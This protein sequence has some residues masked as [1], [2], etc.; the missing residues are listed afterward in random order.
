[1][2]GTYCTNQ[3]L[4]TYQKLLQPPYANQPRAFTHPQHHHPSTT[5]H[6]FPNCLP[7]SSEL[8]GAVPGAVPGSPA[9]PHPNTRLIA[10][11]DLLN[12]STFHQAAVTAGQPSPSITST[13]RP[14][15]LGTSSLLEPSR[16]HLVTSQ[17]PP[18][19][20]PP[21]CNAP[22]P[23]HSLLLARSAEICPS[24]Q[25]SAHERLP[26]IRLL[27]VPHRCAL[28]HYLPTLST[29]ARR[30]ASSLGTGWLP[31]CCLLFPLAR[32]LGSSSS[33]A[34]FLFRQHHFASSSRPQLPFAMPSSQTTFATTH[35]SCSKPS[36][37][38][39]PRLPARPHPILLRLANRYSCHETNPLFIVARPCA[40]L[41][42]PENECCR[43][44]KQRATVRREPPERRI[45]R[46]ATLPIINLLTTAFL[47]SLRAYILSTYIGRCT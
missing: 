37:T 28:A 8:P 18:T 29:H 30:L 20:Q 35:A 12:V 23:G 25:V 36:P 17:N 31:L 19:A 33:S 45:H 24:S 34:H 27:H 44:A 10:L 43:P 47:V 22:L 5:T 40:S 26:Q 16:H 9:P 42:G 39:P 11:L 3:R 14:L 21:A 6:P 13:H 4:A 46:A 2:S 15:D 32:P 7:G 41:S 38:P 1:M